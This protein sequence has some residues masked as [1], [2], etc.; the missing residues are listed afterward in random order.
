MLK[1]SLKIINTTSTK[2]SDDTK[3]G[4]SRYRNI[5]LFFKPEWNSKKQ[6]NVPVI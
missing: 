1:I 2:I 5:D 6:I 3:A 4:L